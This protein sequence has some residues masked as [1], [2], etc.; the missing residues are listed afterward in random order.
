MNIRP[1]SPLYTYANYQVPFSSQKRY[2]DRAK[3]EHYREIGET[4]RERF[5]R[6]FY[7]FWGL[8]P[9]LSKSEKKY[10]A[11]KEKE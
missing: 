6:K 2:S 8:Q 7:E 9:P 5:V 1:I 11:A 3:E 10:I 4:T